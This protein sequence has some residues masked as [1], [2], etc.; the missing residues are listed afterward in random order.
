IHRSNLIG[1][2]IAALQFQP[3]ETLETLGLD[4]TETY[5]VAGLAALNEGQL[6]KTVAVRATRDDGTTVEFEAR[7]RIDTEVEAE[8]FRNGGVLNYVLR[9]LAAGA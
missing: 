5:D 9:S 2:G 1:M 3:G 6:P 8:Y 4:G 7:L